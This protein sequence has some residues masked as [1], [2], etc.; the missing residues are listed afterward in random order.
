MD[1]LGV[2][3]HP[4]RHVRYPRVP[5]MSDYQVMTTDLGVT[6]PDGGEEKWLVR[7]LSFGAEAGQVMALAGPSGSGKTTV[8][9]CLAGVSPH[10]EGQ[11][12][13]SGLHRRPGELA[14]PRQ[15]RQVGIVFQD[16][17]LVQSLDVLDNVALPLQLD[18]TSWRRARK[19]AIGIISAFGLRPAVYRYPS[20]LSGGEQQRV[21]IARAMVRKPPVVLADEPTAHLDAS[22]AGMVAD[23]LGELA[24][25]GTCVIVTSHDPRLLGRI[26][27]VID[28]AV[29]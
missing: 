16:Y 1:L 7:H 22:A 9:M 25:Q 14:K 21:A 12:V 15:L 26:D 17:H 19:T 20:Q 27:H 13:V 29:R 11:V 18:G 10:R 5:A 8:L 3:G 28:M 4:T 23:S 2:G 6:I 24:A